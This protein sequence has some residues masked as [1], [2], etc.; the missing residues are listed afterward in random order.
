M[1]E[2]VRTHKKWMQLLLAL[3][4]APMFIIGGVGMTNNG[5]GGADEVA[6][7]GGTK[8]TQQE[9]DEQQRQQLERARATEGPR[10]DAKKYETPEARQAVLDGLIAQKAVDN[11]IR[12][13]HLTVSNEVLFKEI[14]KMP[15]FQK[16]DG[17]FDEEAYIA[18]LKSQNLSAGQFE[19]MK[20]RDLAL[21]QLNNA[22]GASA[23]APRSVAT[24]VSEIGDQEREVQELL[25]P[26]A[27][28]L[29][30]VQVTPEMVKAYYDKNA[31]LFQVPETV[32]AE[33]VVF[34]A[35]TVE[36]M[37]S[38]DDAEV[39]KF[40]E[41]EKKRFLTP[42]ERKA[43]H[44]LLT[45]KEGDAAQKAAAKAQAE[46]VLAE[47]RA[48]PATFADLA[49]KY[50]QDVASK[51]LGGD[52]GLINKDSVE[53]ELFGP[54]QKLKQGEVSNVVETKF[55]FH[56]I[57]VTQLVP[58][59]YKTLDE[60]KPMISAE[61]KKAKMSKKY[62]ELAETFNNTV[63]EQSESLKPAADKLGLTVQ[64]AD[65]LTRA[66]SAALGASPVNNA[67][68]LNALFA[69]DSL[70]NK[71]NIEA[72]EVAPSVL[73]AG[74]VIEHKPAATRPLAQVEPAIREIVL[75]E[76][77]AK[78]AK[79]AGEAKIAAAKPAG[80]AAGFGEAKVLSRAKPPAISPVAAEAVFKA[81]VTTLPAYV[82]VNLPGT[83]YGVYRIGKVAQPAQPDLASR[84]AEQEQIAGIMAQQELKNYVDALKIKAKTKIKGNVS[85]TTVADA[86]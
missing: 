41:S 39:A 15:E 73:V 8:V 51:E 55:G 31:T 46:K 63:D 37:V 58:E 77:A 21:Q 57:T 53:P 48:A 59:R 16:P 11:E 26:M 76:E 69:A 14:Y 17:S 28:F 4:I 29:P 68:F 33:Y 45:V 56:I 61:L 47:V 52:L 75:K 9:W 81:D 1:F 22:I 62:T 40:Y 32:K 74:R 19:S 60:V 70:K 38:V 10:F 65:G 84:K 6:N 30:Q 86:N 36:K 23:F 83:G 54:I 72:V 82:G 24:R 18:I 44:I 71:R 12:E 35:S 7:V 13:N 78:L 66:P 5:G 42:E 79:K 85:K 25:F 80:D 20:R 34:D 27:Q 43:S 64:V 3:I 49:K 2:F 50:S 67:K